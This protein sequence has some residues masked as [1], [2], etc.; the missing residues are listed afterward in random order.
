MRS[1]EG[2]GAEDSPISGDVS[3]EPENRDGAVACPTTVDG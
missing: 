3:L 1:M 2:L